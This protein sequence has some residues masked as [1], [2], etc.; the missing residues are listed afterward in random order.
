MWQ[1]IGNVEPRC[2]I[3]DEYM[4]L[5][6]DARIIIERP[7][8]KAVRR[9]M[10]IKAA[11]KRGPA[12]AAEAPVVAWRGLVVRNQFFA[13]NPSE[14]GGANARATAKSCAMRLSA[15]GAVAVECT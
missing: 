9:R 5:G 6:L 15:H 4:K 3:R 12:D 11:E 14:I 2:F 7:K 13:L 1:L 8:R 10:A